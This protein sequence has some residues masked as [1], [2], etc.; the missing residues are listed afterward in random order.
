[1]SMMQ[2]IKTMKRNN[3]ISALLIVFLFFLQLFIWLQQDNTPVSW[4]P[5]SHLATSLYYLDLVCHPTVNLLKRVVLH[6]V[7]PPFVAI[8][9]LPF[10]LFFGQSADKA[11][12][13]QNLIYIPILLTSTCLIVRRINQKC[14]IFLPVVLLLT[15]PQIYKIT[16]KYLLDMPL[17]AIVAMCVYGLMCTENFTRKNKSVLLGVMLGIGMLIKVQ[18]II[19][20]MGPL[21]VVIFYSLKDGYNNGTLNKRSSNIIIT[22]LFAM[23]T[24]AFWYLPNLKKVFIVSAF[25]A[26]KDGLVRGCPDPF[27]VQAALYYV[28]T[29]I[30]EQISFTY[31]VLFLIGLVLYLMKITRDKAIIISWIVVPYVILSFFVSHKEARFILPSLPA[32]VLITSIGLSRLPK[33]YFSLIVIP[34][35]AIV[36]MQLLTTNFGVGFIH[37]DYRISLPASHE[38]ILFSSSN[39]YHLPDSKDWRLE[40]VLSAIDHDIQIHDES[41]S[42]IIVFANHC[43]YNQ[44][45]LM[46]YSLL[47]NSNLEIKKTM[48]LNSEYI[49]NLIENDAYRYFVFKTWPNISSSAEKEIYVRAIRFVCSHQESFQ[50]I[51]SQKN[52]DGSSTFVYK[53]VLFEKEYSVKGQKLKNLISPMEIKSLSIDSFSLNIIFEGG[54]APYA[55][56]LY[57]LQ[58]PEKSYFHAIGNK[59]FYNWELTVRMLDI[60]SKHEGVAVKVIDFTGNESSYHVCQAK[61]K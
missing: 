20:L 32:F 47:Q 60:I 4:D 6:T 41:K 42:K 36:V 22:I 44:A 29:L 14:G 26:T 35:I 23:M 13:Y 58:N 61:R 7:W 37:R 57:F 17:T 10:Y 56:E 21:S 45:T 11:I 12:F 33:K 24:A 38:L 27:S 53:K 34:A 43:I 51:F 49:N 54:I 30:N 9:L 50:K 48:W 18:F 8:S 25:S 16:N 46:Y 59:R 1:M 15:Y 19:F 39:P 31:A 2:L 5:A 55:I 28:F 3:I 52:P 40:R